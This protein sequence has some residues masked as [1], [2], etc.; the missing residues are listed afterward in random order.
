MVTNTIKNIAKATRILFIVCLV[1][2]ILNTL[3][4]IPLSILYQVLGMST[5][6][7]IVS[8]SIFLMTILFLKIAIIS[9][10]ID[11]L[12]KIIKDKVRGIEEAIELVK[13]INVACCMLI[14][15]ILVIL[16]IGLGFQLSA[17]PYAIGYCSLGTATF[18]ICLFV[19]FLLL[20]YIK[21]E[22]EVQQYGSEKTYLD[23]QLKKREEEERA[24]Q[25]KLAEKQKQKAIEKTTQLL[26]EIGIKFFIKY[27]DYLQHWSV[28]D[29]AD[30]I[31]KNYSEQTKMERI[32]KAK[33]LFELKLNVTALE[34]IS[35][36]EN[37]MTDDETRNHAQ[38]LLRKEQS[39][40]Q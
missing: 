38:E 37:R 39:T 32:N 40:N 9:A 18:L 5:V 14:G 20:H 21:R 31:E 30:I 26:N 10:C 16:V 2:Q 11:R 15:A 29:L 33:K 24:R 6:E 8:V 7:V 12:G 27:Y 23:A 17:I 34:I 3:V 25:A 4:G 1:W 13:G 28:L 35:N 22:K 36:S 19:S